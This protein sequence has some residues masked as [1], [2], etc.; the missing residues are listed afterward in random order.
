MSGKMSP[1]EKILEIDK[2]ISQIKNDVTYMKIRNGLQK[3]K[4]HQH[5][6]SFITIPSPI[7]EN[8]EM[9]IRRR[10]KEMKSVKKMYENRLEV[11]EEKII[12]LLREKN[13]L[14]IQ[15]FG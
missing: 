2:E 4:S 3:I 7:D 8:K 1:L 12:S 11:F 5:G 14:E 15:I 6:N 10:S 13:A 9:K